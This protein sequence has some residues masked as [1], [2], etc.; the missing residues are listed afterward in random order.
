MVALGLVAT[1]A[2]NAQQALPTINVGGARAA[3][4][5]GPAGHTAGGPGRVTT[6]TPTPGPAQLTAPGFSP[7]K[8]ALPVY[9]DPTGQT[10]T[11]IEGKNFDNMPLLSVREMLQY[12]PGVSFKQGNGPRDIVISIRGSS[13][14]NGFGVRNIVILEDG[15]S[16]T[17]PD[18][19]SRTDLTDPHAYAAID[20]YRGPR[21]PYS[22][23]SP[24]AARSISARA[25]VPK[26]TA[27]MFEAN[28][29][30]SDIS[31]ILPP[32]AKKSA[33]SISLFSP[34]TCAAT[35]GR[36]TIA[37]TRRPSTRPCDGR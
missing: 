12:S 6:A 34:A 37:M 10:F 31:I 7:R 33:T 32:S 15:F 36:C 27:F 28:S 17:Q 20:V 23:T 18:G 35:A 22:A 14:R 3:V 26:S 2:A 1:S 21:P 29:D 9:R 8:L 13:A 16:V 5:R 19:L 4:H 11:T 24:M 25:P 30:R